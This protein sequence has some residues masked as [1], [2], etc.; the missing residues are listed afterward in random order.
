MSRHQFT[1]GSKAQLGDFLPFFDWD[2]QATEPVVPAMPPEDIAERIEA[3]CEDWMRR[4][5]LIVRGAFGVST[6]NCKRENRG[7]DE[8]GQIIWGGISGTYEVKKHCCPLAPLL[9]GLPSRFNPVVDMATV[10]GVDH[11]WVIGFIHGADGEVLLVG[12][13]LERFEDSLS[14][15]DGRAL[16]AKIAERFAVTIQGGWED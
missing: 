6:V 5:G 12:R 13:R 15:V 14:Y 9:E 8:C 7:R 4:G 3:A 10:L 1:R 2:E 11:L 16:G